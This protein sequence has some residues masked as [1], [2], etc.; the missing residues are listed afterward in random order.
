MSTGNICVRLCP[1]FSLSRFVSCPHFFPIPNGKAKA[2]QRGA[3]AQALLLQKCHNEDN[4]QL[5]PQLCLPHA[6]YLCLLFRT[7]RQ[8]SRK[9]LTL[10]PLSALCTLAPP[11]KQGKRSCPN[12]NLNPNAGQL[13]APNSCLFCKHGRRQWR[14]N[15]LRRL[16]LIGLSLRS[17]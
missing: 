3:L 6:S 15:P 17:I 7:T 14:P 1:I 5:T 4:N 16:P 11:A 2:T 12:P 10:P 9:T 13:L 8:K